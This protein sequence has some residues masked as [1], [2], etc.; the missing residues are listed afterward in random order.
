MNHINSRVTYK[1]YIANMEAKIQDKE[2][3]DDIKG[4]LRHEVSFDIDK[5]WEEVKKHVI[6]RLKN[7]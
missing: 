4:L 2:F 3:R 1:Q 6:E 5:G 7:T